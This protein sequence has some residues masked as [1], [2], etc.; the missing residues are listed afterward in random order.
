MRHAQESAFRAYPK[1][2]AKVHRERGRAG[3]PRRLGSGLVACLVFVAGLSASAPAQLL[4]LGAAATPP[5]GPRL[6]LAA[7][8]DALR[9]ELKSLEPPPGAPDDPLLR[10]R[11]RLRQFAIAIFERAADLGDAGAAHV[12][13]GATV[14]GSLPALDALAARVR[15]GPSAVA[16]T[17]DRS[18]SRLPARM[19]DVPAS[20]TELDDALGRW[21]GPIASLDTPAAVAPERIG[22]ATDAGSDPIAQLSR[23]MLLIDAQ[24]AGAAVLTDGTRMALRTETPRLVAAAGT[25]GTAHHARETLAAVTRGVQAC[26]DLPT[27]VQLPARESFRQRVERSIVAALQPDP[28]PGGLA[29]LDR[30]AAAA[31]VVWLVGEVRLTSS[32]Q[33]R[34]L[35]ELAVKAMDP[36]ADAAAEDAS[37]AIRRVLLPALQE[38]RSEAATFPAALESTLV[39]EAKPAWRLL[40][41]ELRKAREVYVNAAVRACTSDPTPSNPALLAARDAMLRGAADLRLLLRISR[42]LEGSEEGGSAA[43]PRES[44]IPPGGE[45][46]A[47][48]QPHVLPDKLRKAA[49]VRLLKLG[50]QLGKPQSRQGATEAIRMLG[51]GLVRC[52]QL[53]ALAAAH[54]ALARPELRQVV[55]RYTGSRTAELLGELDSVRGEFLRAWSEQK[56]D[57]APVVQS[58]PS[59]ASLDALAELLTVIGDAS[60]IEQLLQRAEADKKRPGANLSRVWCTVQSSPAWEGTPDAVRLL[61]SGLDVALADAAAKMLGRDESGGLAAVKTIRRDY[62]AV[63]LLALLERQG[64]VVGLEP[65]SGHLQLAEA[66]VPRGAAATPNSPCGIWLYDQRETLAMICWLSE[67]LAAQRVT[68]SDPAATGDAASYAQ[69]LRTS[70]NSLAEDVLKAQRSAEPTPRTG[71]MK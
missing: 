70:V 10:D 31:E 65:S 33:L 38:S 28:T 68:D 20:P 39:R 59:R 60:D 53:Q 54:L 24:D 11:L 32:R 6:A 16:E 9:Q 41:P 42:W 18:V 35:R 17:L 62:A 23:Q 61:M 3:V 48:S 51:D 34:T 50:Q 21:L 29:E 13:A 27:W 69:S 44:A 37:A 7:S 15:G 67:E 55:D 52:S 45:P 4:K 22:W 56:G 26:A 14:A 12:V 46:D 66:P 30:L 25:I 1:H 47:A 5:A 57:P 64:R 71:A 40:E 19:T 2:H 63:L 58:A 49:A 43:R 8:I 36:G